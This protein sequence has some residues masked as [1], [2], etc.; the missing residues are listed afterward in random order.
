M[1]EILHSNNTKFMFWDKDVI[2]ITATL[3]FDFFFLLSSLVIRNS[4]L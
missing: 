3:Q 4:P 1:S 2:M